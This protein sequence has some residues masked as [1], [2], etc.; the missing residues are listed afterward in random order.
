MIV[1]FIT[2]HNIQVTKSLNSGTGVQ[3]HKYG[4]TQ[5]HAQKHF[6]EAKQCLS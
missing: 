3:L 5:H 6:L 2:L 1:Y 4:K